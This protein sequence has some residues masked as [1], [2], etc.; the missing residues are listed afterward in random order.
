MKMLCLTCPTNFDSSKIT[1]SSGKIVFKIFCDECIEKHK[2]T[3]RSQTM[4]GFTTYKFFRL[5]FPFG[6]KS[7][8]IK[9]NYFR[10]KKVSGIKLT[11]FM[12]KKESSK[13]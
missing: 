1:S 8:S 10:I 2:K 5:N 9:R 12:L 7:K 3:K 4:K 6:K 13:N 11:K